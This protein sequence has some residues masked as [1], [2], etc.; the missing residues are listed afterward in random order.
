MAQQACSLCSCTRA[1]VAAPG[2]LK[3]CKTKTLAPLWSHDSGKPRR[4]VG[5]VLHRLQSRFVLTRWGSRGAGNSM[6][7]TYLTMDQ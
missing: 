4:Q 6:F 5:Q 1:A 2:A 7:S 3:C